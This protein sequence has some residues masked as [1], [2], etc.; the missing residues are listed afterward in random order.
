VPDEPLPHLNEAGALRQVMD[1]LIATGE[2][3]KGFGTGD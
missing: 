1:E 2:F 3:P